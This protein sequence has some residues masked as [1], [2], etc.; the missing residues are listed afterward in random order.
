M[1]GVK[2][3]HIPYKGTA[4][5]LVDLIA[6]KDVTT[7]FASMASVVP[8]IKAGRLR[9]LTLTSANRI[10][11]LPDVMTAAEAGIP[12]LE[13]YSWNGVFAPI[14]TPKGIIDK[15]NQEIAAILRAP[16]V[17]ERLVGLGLDPTGGTAEM[18]TASVK[19]D[20]ERWGKII[21]DSGIE[22]SQL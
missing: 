1:T 9:A 22:K 18:F 11:A 4:P 7:S 5:S 2:L 12:G 10:S 15:L 20:L 3:T 14:G 8:P 17:V 16:D 13:V 21:R 6:G 19:A